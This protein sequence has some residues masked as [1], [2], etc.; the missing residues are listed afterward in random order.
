MIDMIRSNELQNLI[1]FAARDNP[2]IVRPHEIFG[3]FILHV[4]VAFS[5]S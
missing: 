3:S 4:A 2:L 1:V 5:L